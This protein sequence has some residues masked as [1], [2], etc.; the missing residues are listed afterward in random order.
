MSTIF[1]LLLWI[2]AAWIQ[3]CCILSRM[4]FFF[5]CV[6]LLWYSTG[7]YRHKRG[8]R[9]SFHSQFQRLQCGVACTG[10]FRH[11]GRFNVM[12]GTCSGAKQL[13]SWQTSCNDSH[14][15]LLIKPSTPVNS[16]MDQLMNEVGAL[17]IQGIPKASSLDT[18]ALP[19]TQKGALWI[20][21]VGNIIVERA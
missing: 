4:F 1:S 9:T 2:I 13:T 20:Q 14:R 6:L 11:V 8:G 16:L 5:S 15:A 18:V 12:L 3:K 7:H 19:S 21:A 10:H 17:A